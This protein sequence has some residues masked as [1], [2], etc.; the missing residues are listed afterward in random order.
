MTYA[1]KVRK[2]TREDHE[3]VGDSLAEIAESLRKKYPKLN[4]TY[5]DLNRYLR[6]RVN[7][8]V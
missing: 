2:I 3:I 6:Q 8:S 7:D 5:E 1:D 4:L